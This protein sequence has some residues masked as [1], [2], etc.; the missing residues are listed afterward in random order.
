MREHMLKMMSYVNELDMLGAEIDAIS[1][2]DKVLVSLPHSFNQFMLNY[3][4]NKMDANLS[5]LLNILQA[6]EDIIKSH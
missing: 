5:E 3:N 1:K 4:I 6:I 2:I